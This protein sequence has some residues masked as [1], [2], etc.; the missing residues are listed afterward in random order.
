MAAEGACL[1]VASGAGPAACV[2]VGPVGLGFEVGC[3]CHTAP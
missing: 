3:S 2:E 1:V